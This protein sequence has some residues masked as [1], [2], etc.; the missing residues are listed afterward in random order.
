MAAGTFTKITFGLLMAL[1]IGIMTV[2]LIIDSAP[3]KYQNFTIGQ[4]IID[5]QSSV[6]SPIQNISNLRDEAAKATESQNAF[7]E[8]SIGDVLLVPKIVVTGIGVFIKSIPKIIQDFVSLIF[9]KFPEATG[10]DGQPILIL[11]GAGIVFTVLFG[12]IKI[13]GRS[14]EV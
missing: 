6:K 12:L 4:E 8:S 5:L 3:S 9:S 10:G 1:A 13:M 7:S 14:S 11:V 2:N